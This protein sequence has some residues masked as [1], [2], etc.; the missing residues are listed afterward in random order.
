MRFCFIE[1]PRFIEEN[2]EIL[3]AVDYF[4]YVNV[5]VKR[6]LLHFPTFKYYYLCVRKVNLMFPFITIALESI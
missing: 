4:N 3:I 6:E 5:Y 2:T 1:T